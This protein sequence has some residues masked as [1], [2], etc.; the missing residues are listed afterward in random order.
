M[1]WHEQPQEV[2]T[3]KP[4][5][6]CLP[7][8]FLY[9]LHLEPLLYLFFLSLAT[10]FIDAIPE[11]DW[12]WVLIFIFLGWLLVLFRYAYKVMDQTAM[13]L[14]TPDQAAAYEE[15]DSGRGALPFKLFGIFI[16][17]A[18]VFGTADYYIG[19]LFSGAV[20]IYITFSIPAALMLLSITRSF[21]TA[22]NPLAV[23]QVMTVVGIPYLG[24]CAFL[25]LLGASISATDSI[26]GTLRTSIPLW[27][28]LW[29]STSITLY[30]ILIMFNMM[31]Y[32]IYQY[33]HLLGVHVKRS[34][35]ENSEG[36]TAGN[37]KGISYAELIASGQID[38]ALELAQ[39]ERRDHPGDVDTNERL[40]KLL[41][42]SNRKEPLLAHA[43]AYLDLLLQKNLDGEAIQLYG[44]M[45]EHDPN[46]APE[47]PAQL[48]QLAKAARQRRDPAQA[49]ALVKGFDKRF[50]D[51]P[52]IPAVYF[53]AA[54]TLSEDLR[55]DARAREILTVLL[56]RYPAHPI[57]DP[58]QK[59]LALLEKMAA[60][61]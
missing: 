2:P 37:G 50:P 55:K 51:N 59:L 61:A 48:L 33:H 30:F 46:F 42:L 32:V 6:L 47:K 49:L 14:L 7:R 31:G 26:L 24:L 22:L 12:D 36:R 25:F 43:R 21:W 35:E 41:L 58:A 34:H 4:F 16:V 19:G 5:W 11:G 38:K 13:G 53:F 17:F 3:I 23:F 40:H 27:L 60:Q 9:P 44:A 39:T 10:V 18:F 20:L 57:S 56:K 1:A 29:I 15:D 28:L 8:F 45:R 54:Q 52:E